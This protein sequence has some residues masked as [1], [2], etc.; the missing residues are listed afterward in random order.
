MTPGCCR[1]AAAVPGGWKGRGGEPQPQ[2]AA[3]RAP[4]RAPAR[5]ACAAPRP[6]ERRVGGSGLE[7][8]WLSAALRLL[9]R[10]SRIGP[11]Y[12]FPSGALCKRFGRARIDPPAPQESIK[13]AAQPKPAPAT[14]T[15]ESALS[16]RD[17][18]A[19]PAR[20]LRRTASLVTGWGSAAPLGMVASSLM[21]RVRGV[22]QIKFAPAPPQFRCA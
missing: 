20:H 17:G 4:I 9:R 12:D 15:P 11:G 14:P 3:V 2:R 1:P 21:G 19:A 7:P 8:G 16:T 18:C 6:S 13:L 5:H 10:G 22:H